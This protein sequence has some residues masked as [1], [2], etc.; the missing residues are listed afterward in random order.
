MYKKVAFILFVLFNSFGFAQKPSDVLLLIDGREITLGEFQH[1]YQKNQALNTPSEQNLEEN[2]RL[3]VN[4]KLKVIEA[5]NLGLDKTDAFIKELAGYRKQL[6]KP[7]LVSKQAV[8][9]LIDEAYER[10][11]YEIDISHILVKLSPDAS[12]KDSLLAWNK[13]SKFRKQIVDDGEEFEKVAREYSDDPSARKNRGHLG[14]FTVFQ[15]VYS[16]ESAAYNTP[17]GEISQPF[18][19]RFGY[20]IIWVHNKRHSRGER[21]VAHIMLAVPRGT[22]LEDAK[23]TEK[24]IKNIAKKLKIPNIV[25]IKYIVRQEKKDITK[26]PNIGPSIGTKIIIE[27]INAVTFIAFLES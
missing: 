18:R 11:Q 13:I 24:K 5:E 20:H 4:F 23:K 19:S 6:A 1:L 8:E 27:D 21:Q 25:K 7:Y 10:M 3:F 15:M 22:Q 9:R 17:V 16:V 2:L 14:F 12:P 26:A